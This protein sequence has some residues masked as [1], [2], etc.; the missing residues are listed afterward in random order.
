MRP[1]TLVAMILVI[2]GALNW[3]LI[4]IFGFN[5]VTFLF[6]S[7]FL[8]PLIYILVGLAGVY[9]IFMLARLASREDDVCVPGHY[10]RLAQH[11]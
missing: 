11:M 9:E 5:L 7:T 4:G 10:P 2:V 6:G 1:L 8:T 3:G